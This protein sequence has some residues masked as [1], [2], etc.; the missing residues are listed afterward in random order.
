MKYRQLRSVWA[1]WEYRKLR[2]NFQRNLE[3][4]NKTKE[5]A[6]EKDCT[7]PARLALAWLLA[8][9]EEIILILCDRVT[10]NAGVTKNY[11]K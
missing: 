11:D 5:I 7:P 3:L 6:T 10:E 9:G 8:R 4:V 2:E 1:A